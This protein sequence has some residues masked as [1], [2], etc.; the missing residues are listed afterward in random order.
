MWVRHEP[1]DSLLPE[2]TMTANL[3]NGCTIRKTHL[4]LL[5]VM[6]IVILIFLTGISTQAQGGFCLQGPKEE[7]YT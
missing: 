1:A 2:I 6:R 7:L 5:I 4:I 3:T